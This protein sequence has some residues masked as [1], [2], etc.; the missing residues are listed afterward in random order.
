MISPSFVLASSPD[1]HLAKMNDLGQYFREEW[2]ALVL[3][4]VVL[5]L[6]LG[7]G[8]QYLNPP[9][10]KRRGLDG[11]E[12]TPYKRMFRNEDFAFLRHSEVNQLARDPFLCKVVTDKPPVPAKTEPVTPVPVVQA[13]QIAAPTVAAPVEPI[14]VEPPPQNAVPARPARTP[15]HYQPQR[16]TYVFSRQD[17]N[18]QTTAMLKVQLRG[19]QPEI[20]T[21]APGK[22]AFGFTVL[23]IQDDALRIRDAKGKEVTIQYG[24]SKIV[25]ARVE[26]E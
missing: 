12:A 18:G 20:L 6:V 15:A 17:D 11:A 10:R 26:G 22:K 14:T 4:G 19:K 3:A 7:L 25:T 16:I 5:L 1:K 21:L 2:E 23:S 8:V 24:E 13:E 9:A